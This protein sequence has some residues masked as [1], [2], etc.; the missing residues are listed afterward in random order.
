MLRGRREVGGAV[1]E[2]RFIGEAG[3]AAEIA[4]LVEPSLNDM[5][6][7]IVR[8]SIS[9]RNGTTVQIMAERPDGTI[10]VEDCADISR[11]LSP[12]LDAHDPIAGQ[13]TL[14][15]SSPGIDRPLARPSDFVAWA[16]HE[17]RIETKQLVGGRRRFRGVLKGLAGN[18]VELEVPPDQGGPELTL[19]IGLISEARLVLTDELIRDTLRRAK[20]AAA[21]NL[22]PAAAPDEIED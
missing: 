2:A 4:A 17:A 12:L 21:G 22:P 13:Y 7:R 5:G 18:D 6:F 19:P 8:V 14:E 15:I 10:T 9:G 1:S 16:G 11:Q 3:V 20:K